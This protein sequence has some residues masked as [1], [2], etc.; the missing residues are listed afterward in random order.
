MFPYSLLIYSALEIR[1][2]AV[3]QAG[4]QIFISG[5]GIISFTII[6]RICFGVLNAPKRPAEF[7]FPSIYSYRS[8][9]ISKSL[10]SFSNKSSKPATTFCNAN[11]SFIL[12]VA[13]FK[14]LE[15]AE[16]S[17]EFRLIKK[18]NTLS[19]KCLWSAR[20]SIPLK[21]LQRRACSSLDSPK[22]WLCFSPESNSA[23]SISASLSSICFA[24]IR[25]VN[26][27]IT[28]V[29]WETPPAITS[30]HICSILFFTTDGNIDTSLSEELR[31]ISLYEDK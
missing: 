18:I 25:Y 26:C 11:G 10:I 15:K 24:N 6:S 16:F 22:I 9:C 12:N 13:C 3:P 7:N 2:P 14:Y 28:S 29:G 20:A 23:I 17:F 5:V 27:S 8:P 19:T 1:N 30:S 31:P 4:S 21:F